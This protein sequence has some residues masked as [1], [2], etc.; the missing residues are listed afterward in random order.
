M[1]F[2][3]ESHVAALAF[4]LMTS[5]AWPQALVPLPPPTQPLAR[6]FVPNHLYFMK[7]D[8]DNRNDGLTPATAWRG[9]GGAE[10]QNSPCCGNTPVHTIECGDVILMNTGNYVGTA[11]AGAD[12]NSGG[13][14][15]DIRN[16]YANINPAS[17]PSTTGGIDDQGG[18]NFVLVLCAGPDVMSC[19]VTAAD[20]EAFRVAKGHWAFSGIWATQNID[21][22]GGCFT[23][24]NASPTQGQT[25]HYQ[26]F[27]NSITS[28]CD[29][30]GY[31]SGGG[32]GPAGFDQIAVVGSVAFDSAW[33]ISDFCG[34]GVSLF[35][36]DPD[37]SPGTHI[38]VSQYFGAY[39]SNHQRS[40]DSKE[41]NASFRGGD[42]PHTDGE[43]MIFDTY[44]AGYTTPGSWNK[45]AVL[46]NAVI[47]HSGNDCI[48]SFP[49]GDGLT[50]EQGQYY[51][52][53]TTC[54]ANDQDPRAGCNGE[55][56]LHAVYPTGTSLYQIRNNI[57]F[58]TLTSCGGAGNSVTHPG[59]GLISGAVSMDA[60]QVTIQDPC[61]SVDPR[62]HPLDDTR[63]DVSNNWIWQSAGTTTNVVGP[64]NTYI[65]DM[66]FPGN[67][68]TEPTF[69][70]PCFNAPW[71]F[72]INTYGNPGLTN[73]A[74]L[75]STTPDCTGY[76]FVTTCMNEKYGVYDKV[77][78]TI[79]PLTMGYQKPG[80]CLNDAT[81]P[82]AL[83]YPKWLKGI[84][85]VL[86]I[87]GFVAGS[88]LQQREGLATKPCN[89]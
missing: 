4:T 53:N 75:F 67:C 81:D 50:N 56:Q 77:K 16:D 37:T 60:Y 31:G 3:C 19:K 9:P 21:G 70:P 22:R 25:E 57:F 82:R 55:L 48:Q 20:L 42:H 15:G 7:P 45:S 66:L 33:S 83:R 85:G 38:Y 28:V 11:P 40:S 13:F 29:L 64:P 12:S 84:V 63:I 89:M 41:C 78:P 61:C 35:P 59:I 86:A 23:G 24:V 76:V 46:E 39:N 52:L 79:A 36:G 71:H 26:A 14:V 68:P 72:G 5:A 47:W 54:Y 62:S 65:V 10:F 6:T 51:V 27:I 18:I 17:C 69:T 87:D 74:A 1:K 49:Q 2:R 73:P 88:R 58:A 30:S 8:G 44:A 34:S 43:G 32:A 80:P